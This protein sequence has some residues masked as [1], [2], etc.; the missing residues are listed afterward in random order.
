MI[1]LSY[2]Q[3]RASLQDAASVR[4]PPS[5]GSARRLA[6]GL[7]FAAVAALATVATSVVQHPAHAQSA[8]A[9]SGT[10]AGGPT[11]TGP[12]AT[13][14]G[15]ALAPDPQAV[16]AV[17]AAV[18]GW[19]KGR[20][21]VEEIR[22]TPLPGIYEVRIGSD[23]V[24]VDD[25]GQYV[26]VEGNLVEMRSNRNLTRERVDELMTIN[27]KDLPLALAIKQV[28]GTG[29][30]IVAVFE[31]P[32]CGYCRTLRR[33]LN[34]LK[35]TTVYT[36]AYPILAP[37]SEVKARKAMCA[38]D[39]SKA[40][41][42]MMLTGKVP[43]NPGTCDNPVAKVRELGQKLG[44]AATPTVFFVNGKR[45][46]GYMPAPQFEKMLDESARS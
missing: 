36:F 25:K 38:S 44:I 2:S 24:Y 33:D 28:N 30:R 12:A 46:Q 23:L 20:Y 42:E 39:K 13:G 19:L 3:W 9:A 29:K 34:A 11:T 16:A 18:E 37:D 22:K 40:W 15:G 4:R 7:A 21:K 6:R 1:D 32:N 17:R 27:F 43:D 26:F 31:D 8:P 5:S 14:P 41:N 35:D 45:L 10:A